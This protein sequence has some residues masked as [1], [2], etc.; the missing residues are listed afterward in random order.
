MTETK[1][2]PANT[3]RFWGLVRKFRVPLL[4]AVHLFLFIAIFWLS[5]MIRNGRWRFAETPPSFLQ[6]A[7]LVV[8]IKLFVFYALRSFHGWWRHV[9]FND[10]LLLVRAST[11]AAAAISVLVLVYPY[12]GALR[13]TLVIDWMLTIVVLSAFRSVW[14]VWDENVSAAG[15]DRQRT[16]LI[17]DDTNMAQLGHLINSRNQMGHRIVGL[18]APGN[19]HTRL[20]FSDLRVVGH[21]GDIARLCTEFRVRKLLVPAGSITGQ[22]LRELIDLQNDLD[23]SISVVPHLSEFLHGGTTIPVRPV[24]YEDLLRRDPVSLDMGA[25][26]KM[27]T[28]ATVM[29][30]GAGGSIG[31]ELCRQ[32]MQF[33]P[34]TLILLGRGENRIFHINNEL[35]EIIQAEGA[36][37]KLVNVIGS[38]TDQTRMAEVFRTLQPDVVFHAA[39]HKHVPLTEQNVGEAIINN[40]HGTRTVADLASEFGVRKFVLI[41]TDKAVNPSSV[42][43]CTKQLAERYC[44]ALGANSRT[45]FVA[46]RFGNVLGSDGSVVPIFQKQIE[47]G[48]P[49]RITDPEMTRYFM[50]IPEATQLVLQAVAMGNS[51][52]VLVLEMGKP[53]KIVDLAKDL[54]RLA[55]LPANAI[56]IV[57][58]G[59]RPGEKTYEE[60]YYAGEESTQTPHPKILASRH[61]HFDPDEVQIQTHQIVELAFSGPAAIREKLLELIPEYAKFYSPAPLP[62]PVQKT[63]HR[64]GSTDNGAVKPVDPVR[65]STRPR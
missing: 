17:G 56:D 21:L 57:Y 64:D 7:W 54:I 55:G 28:G 33:A 3:S 1:I 10:L 5:M 48:G 34:K 25:I 29:V 50:T 52:D 39:A 45:Q 49:V 16:L 20:R 59:K 53:V 19:V 46:T 22:R 60:L 13:G 41:S 27:V 37:T 6:L 4:V 62:V 32:I 2:H 14:R 35:S 8:P 24:R 43:G 9:T 30:T 47:A 15:A 42:M 65:P 61:R 36:A 58:T 40:V 31:S 63:L 12:T 38:V 26:Q 11:V 51:G 18:V 23:L 44:I